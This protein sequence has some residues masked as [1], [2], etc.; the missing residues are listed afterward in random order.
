V[1]VDFLALWQLVVRADIGADGKSRRNSTT[2][3]IL[4]WIKLAEGEGVEP[5]TVRSARLSRPVACRHA[6][7]SLLLFEVA[8]PARLE[9]ATP[10]FKA[11]CSHPLSYGQLRS[12]RERE[13][14]RVVGFEPTVSCVRGRHSG[15]S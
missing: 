13:M 9:R 3:A 11:R 6:P 2:I 4:Q 5:S 15:P 1:K 14:V 12:R 7:P 8:V 10:A